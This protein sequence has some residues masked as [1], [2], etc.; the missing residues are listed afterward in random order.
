MQPLPPNVLHVL[1]PRTRHALY[2]P[3]TIPLT[4]PRVGIVRG[5]MYMHG[6]ARECSY[7]VHT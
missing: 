7:P 2:I 6:H 1:R 5:C 4:P 3:L